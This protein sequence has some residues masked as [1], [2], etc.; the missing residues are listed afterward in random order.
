MAPKT[1]RERLAVLKRR[2][3]YLKTLANTGEANSWDLQELGALR[4]AINEL[5]G[6]LD[7]VDEIVAEPSR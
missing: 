6:V 2:R 1:P 4:W 7:L 3:D 5:E